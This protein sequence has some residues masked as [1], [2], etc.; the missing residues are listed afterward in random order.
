MHLY[1]AHF[2]FCMQLEHPSSSHWSATQPLRSTAHQIIAGRSKPVNGL[3]SQTSA[4]RQR[5]LAALQ[6]MLQSAPAV[7]QDMASHAAEAVAV[8]YLAEVRSGLS[9]KHQ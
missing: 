6:L 4:R 7:L 1:D 8:C 2:P 5:E 3:P 9:G